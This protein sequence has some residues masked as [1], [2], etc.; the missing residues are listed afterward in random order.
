MDNYGKWGIVGLI[1]AALLGGGYILYN[2]SND[3]ANVLAVTTGCSS[4]QNK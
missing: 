3:N 1:L 4:C 2:S